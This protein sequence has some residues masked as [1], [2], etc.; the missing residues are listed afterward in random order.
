MDSKRAKTARGKRFLKNRE[1]KLVENPRTALIIRGQKTSGLINTVLTDLFMLKKPFSV[2]FKRHNAVHPF[3]DI[4]PLEFMA[5]KNDASLFAFGTHSKKR[6]HNVVFGRM[7]DHHL[8]DM[9]ELQL[10]QA[11]P[12]AH[13]ASA[14]RGGFSIESKPC[15]IFQGD[16]ENTTALKSLRQLFL[17]F[18]NQR[19]VDAISSLGI[20]RTLVFSALPPSEGESRPAKIFIRHYVAT[21]KKSAEGTA[22]Y[23]EL[24][25]V[26]P[27][28]DFALGRVQQ[29]SDDL[30]KQAMR[31]PSV[32][33][34]APKRVKNVSHD[35][36][37]GRQGRIHI[38]KQDL[39]Q[40][41][42]A[43][44]KG[45]RRQREGNEGEGD[46][47]SKK[48]RKVEPPSKTGKKPRA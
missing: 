20:E 15:I 39:S 41:A 48:K 14:A 11:L 23:T 34:S 40:M 43:R 13:F 17:D 2:H 26:G 7:Y 22:P 24:H 37:K 46:Q 33:P 1:P 18:F 16:W 32:T 45:L 28:L 25:E 42:T 9:Y 8:L 3:E 5:Q 36:L 47:P 35:K 38:P 29:P 6:P 27:S 30:M 44:M 21:L 19:R 31:Q 10:L 12:M 4:T